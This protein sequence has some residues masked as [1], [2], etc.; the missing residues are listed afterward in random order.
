LIN[1]HMANVPGASMLHSVVINGNELHKARYVRLGEM[2]YAKLSTELFWHDVRKFPKDYAIRSIY[3]F[4]QLWLGRSS[5]SCA[6]G[7]LAR[8]IG[9]EKI[10][11]AD[12]PLFPPALI[13][14]RIGERYAVIVVALAL[15]GVVGMTRIGRGRGA[16]LL[17]SVL[18][19][20]SIVYVPSH[21]E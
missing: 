6:G 14:E 16:L 5:A 8:A 13:E 3:R 10:R 20:T 18:V 21:V 11:Y 15:I 1:A 9:S 17:T 19:F 7:L 2:G 4:F 12:V